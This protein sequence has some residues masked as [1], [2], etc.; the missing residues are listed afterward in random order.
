M[1]KLEHYERELK[2]SVAGKRILNVIHD[3]IE[4]VMLL[5]NHNR[6]VMVTWQR[7]QGPA[8]IASVLENGIDHSCF[9]KEIAGIQ[10]PDLMLK[11]ADCLQ[12]NGSPGLRKSIGLYTLFT[13]ECVQECNSANEVFAYISNADL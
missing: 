5:V 8:F 9:K 7:N 2:K 12:D 6:N 11:M 13:L 1:Y 10:F 3:H 4:E